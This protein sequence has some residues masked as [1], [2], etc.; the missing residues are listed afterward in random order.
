M[1]T[2]NPMKTDIYD[3]KETVHDLQKETIPELDEN[4]SV[5]GLP[6]YLNSVNS[7]QIQN[8]IITSSE[9]ANEVFPSKAKFEKNIISHAIIQNVTDIQANPAKVSVMVGIAMNDLEDLFKNDIFRFDRKSKIFINFF[10]FHFQYDIVLSRTLS[11]NNKMIYSARYDMSIDNPLSDITNPYLK[12][13]F[14][15]YHDDNEY[16]FIYCDLIQISLQEVQS[17]I[18]TSTPIENKVFEF[19]FDEQLAGFAIKVTENEKMTRLTP[20]FEGIGID[21]R[22][23]DYCFYSYMDLNNIRVTFDSASYMPSINALIEA[24]I[25]STLGAKGNFSFLNNIMI[26]ITSDSYGY[27]NIPCRVL[28][29]SE[30]SGGVDKKTIDEL[31]KLIPK[32]ALSRGSITNDTT[33]NNYFNMINTDE[34]RL[35]IMKRVDNQF[36][37]SYFAYMVLKDQ[38]NNIIP[39]NTVDL[40]MDETQWQTNVNRKYTLLP[41]T[42]LHLDRA[43]GI[44]RIIS[45][46]ERIQELIQD[47][48]ETF[49]YGLPLMIVMTDDPLYISYYSTII[50][51][52]GYLDFKYI[53]YTAPCQFVASAITW[54][55]KFTE[56][57]DCYK[58]SIPFTQN[59]QAE[60]GILGFDTATNSLIANN[61]KVFAVFYNKGETTPYRY[62]ECDMSEYEYGMFFYTYTATIKTT[63]QIDDKNLIRLEG[64]K[65]PGTDDEAYGYMS[66]NISVKIYIL[67]KFQNTEFGRHDLDGVVPGLEGYTVCN[68]FDVN[69]GLSLYENYTDIINSTVKHISYRDEDSILH[70]GY[71]IKSIP[72]VRY[73]YMDDEECIQNFIDELNYKKAYIDRA[74]YVLENN[75]TIDFKLFNTYGPSRIYSLDEHGTNMVSRVNLTLNFR[76]R[77]VQ[78]T[79]SY[80]VSYII[81]DIKDIL[82]DLNDISS[83]HIPN[84]ITTITNTYRN[85]IEYFEFLGI[86]DYG[87]GVQHLYKNDVTDVTIV[88][89]FLTVHTNEDLSPDINIEIA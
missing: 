19:S 81:K 37:R 42:C 17:K 35:E 63:D 58:L 38:Y 31:R 45:D 46:Q 79:D 24:E 89:E 47:D 54:K 34:N 67:N 53:N 18:V 11:I 65:I 4:T 57:R 14:V 15:Q 73:S 25:W 5:V 56:D 77:L 30:S 22:L 12:A 59:I 80:T 33:L 10:E 76:L 55:R 29:G 7:L 61:L 64:L 9:L 85:A 88:P 66:S 75:F 32:E 83:L 2:I 6:G 21:P 50:D 86:N 41:G 52:V 68:M 43:T 69:D 8:S 72:V 60:M 40:E 16:L 70:N 20:V 74:L 82:E 44:S 23:T 48:K 36:E 71:R 84:L 87:P 1:A 78:S 27:K 3:I 49:I 26:S 13:P 62:I 51:Q 39:T 28:I